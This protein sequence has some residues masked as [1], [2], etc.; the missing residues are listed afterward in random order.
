MPLSVYT[1]EAYQP[2]NFSYAFTL[3]DACLRDDTRHAGKCTSGVE[4]HLRVIQKQPR[5]LA[6]TP[7]RCECRAAR[8]L[9]D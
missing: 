6:Y 7:R 2:H 5:R 8:S 4:W 3:R 1:A 9:S